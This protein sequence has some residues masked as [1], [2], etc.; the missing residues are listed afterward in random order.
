MFKKGKGIPRKMIT[1]FQFFS[2]HQACNINL[3]HASSK[4][5]QKK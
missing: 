3:G 2:V 5:N 1:V 4:E